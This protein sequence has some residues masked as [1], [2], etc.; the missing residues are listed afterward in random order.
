MKASFKKQVFHFREAAKTSRDILY[1]KESYFLKI[2]DNASSG[3][4]ECSFIRGLSCDR[5]EKYE[6]KLEELC[7]HIDHHEQIDLTDFPSI[8]FGLET[9]LRDL[10]HRGGHIIFDNGFHS[11][12]KKIPINGLIWMSDFPSMMSQIKSKIEQGFECIKI[13]IG[14]F[15]FD[16]ELDFLKT[17]RRNYP[18]ISL[19]LDANGAFDAKDAL[20]KLHLLSEIGPHSIEQPVKAGQWE[21]MAWICEKSP[22]KIALDEELIGI[23]D[24]EK[25]RALLD[26]IKPHFLVL[27]PSLSGGFQRCDQWIT[28][29]RKRKISWWGT[30]ALESNV[31]LNA[32][33]QWISGYDTDIPHGLGTGMLY[34]NNIPSPLKVQNGYIYWDVNEKWGNMEY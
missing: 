22:V 27:K 28:F 6:D 26:T 30:S 16:E 18:R 1:E 11:G 13:K 19:R 12:Q 34:T 32:I 5:M 17:V 3:S 4:G 7:R 24:A 31:G 25:Q 2:R 33:A 14:Q 9:A 29:A 21:E 20:L 23:H 15:C 10:A 8:R